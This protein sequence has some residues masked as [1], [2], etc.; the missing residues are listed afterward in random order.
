M[1]ELQLTPKEVQLLIRGLE[2]GTF[3]FGDLK[4]AYDLRNKLEEIL[5]RS[6]K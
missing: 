6:K 1:I 4:L 5:L 3:I 2:S